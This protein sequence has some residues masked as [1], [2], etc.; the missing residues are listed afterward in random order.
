MRL[1]DLCCGLKGFSQDFADHGWEVTTVDIDPRF[2]PDIIADVNN[3]HLE[4]YYDVIV[5]SPACTD[6]SRRSLPA[7]W[8]C[9]GGKHIEP[10]MR[11][12]LNCYRII[13]YLKP[14]YWV[15]EN[16]RGA[17][18]YFDI[19]LGEYRKK[20]GSRY[21]WGEFP[22]FD[23]S[24]K[25]GKWKLSPSPDRAAIRSEIPRGLTRALRLAIEAGL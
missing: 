18:G 16:V 11:L 3:L 17:R 6:Y 8:K 20:V 12:F 7:S 9:N 15:I 19:V 22:I 5:S 21:L 4:G 24:A 14:K 2:S 10:D 23:T 1:L 25:Y 13:R